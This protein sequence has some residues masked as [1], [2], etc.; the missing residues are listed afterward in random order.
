LYTY[1]YYIRKFPNH[2]FLLLGIFVFVFIYPLIDAAT[3]FDF[4]GP[5]SYSMIILSI[6]SAIER[7]KKQQIKILYYLVFVSLL[8]I[9]LLYFFEMPV[10]RYFSYVFNIVVFMRATAI[11]IRQILES[12]DVTVTVLLDAINGYLLLGVMLA[13]TNTLLWQI[14][15]DSFS[16]V[17]GR[18]VDLIYFSFVTITSIGYGDIAPQ[19]DIAKLVSVFF[20]LVSQLY[21]TIIIALI[22]GKFL[23]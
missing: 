12:H 13:L 20:G 2:L 16:N 9:W 3:V 6:L 17:S 14:N 18:M 22:I 23:K 4:L 7:R 10:L 1:L 19:S 5:L 21:L 8:F 11:M 15:H